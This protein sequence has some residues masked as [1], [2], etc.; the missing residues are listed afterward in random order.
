MLQKIIFLII[1]FVST[2]NYSQD[3]KINIEL[4]YP[5]PIDKNFV[6]KNFNGIVDLGLKFRFLEFNIVNIGGSLNTGYLK[7][8]KSDRVQPFDVNLFT[9]QPRVFAELNLPSIPKFHPSIGLGYSIFMFKPVNNRTAFESNISTES[10]NESGLNINTTLAYDITDEILV[11]VQYDF[12][13]IGVD[14]DVPDITY[15]TNINILK[16]GLGYRF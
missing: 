12:V 7:N 6:G 1:C 14:N 11:I 13:K 8:S 2:K 3:S 15:N 10:I 5:I 9:I 4:S 16:I